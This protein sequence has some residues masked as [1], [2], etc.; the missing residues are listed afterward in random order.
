MYFYV[1]YADVEDYVQRILNDVV[2][3]LRLDND[4]DEYVRSL[5]YSGQYQISYLLNFFF[6]SCFILL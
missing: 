2:A 1:S 4:I 3:D 5:L 6:H